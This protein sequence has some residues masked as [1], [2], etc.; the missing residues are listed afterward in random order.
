MPIIIKEI[1]VRTTIERNVKQELISV[2]VI[3]RIKCE[4][5]REIQKNMVVVQRK[6]KER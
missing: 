4:L 5:L 6:R 1:Y 2:D 3:Q